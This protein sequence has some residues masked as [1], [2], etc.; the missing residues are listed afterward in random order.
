MEPDVHAPHSFADTESPACPVCGQPLYGS[1]AHWA[2]LNDLIQ[3]GWEQQCIVEPVTAVNHAEDLLDPDDLALDLDSPA[4]LPVHHHD[5]HGNHESPKDQLAEVIPQ[6][7]RMD[8]T[9]EP[10]PGC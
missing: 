10:K 3:L 9:S 4:P 2:T 1:Q 7:D 8:E 5:L 6:L